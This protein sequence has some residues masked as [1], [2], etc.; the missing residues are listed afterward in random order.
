MMKLLSILKV[1]DGHP[2]PWHELQ[3]LALALWT[4]GQDLS[5][6]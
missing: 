5:P 1:D 4:N 6:H 3:E 2:E